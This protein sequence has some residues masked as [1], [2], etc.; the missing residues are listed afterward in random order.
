MNIPTLTLNDGHTVPAV[1]FGT[2]P[3]AGDDSRTTA[4]SALD[5]GYRLL[6]TALR[7]ENE[8]GVGR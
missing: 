4:I 1:G 5:A 7:Y 6:D 3:H 2:F 8:Q